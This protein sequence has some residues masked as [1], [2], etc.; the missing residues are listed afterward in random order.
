MTQFCI[1]ITGQRPTV[2]HHACNTF[3]VSKCWA[4]I[5]WTLKNDTDFSF[6]LS[7]SFLIATGV[8]R[9][10]YY[11]NWIPYIKHKKQWNSHEY[12][13]AVW[14]FGEEICPSDP[15]RIV[16]CRSLNI[17]E[18]W[19]QKHHPMSWFFLIINHWQLPG[20]DPNGHGIFQKE[21]F[22][23]AFTCRAFYLTKAFSSPCHIT[24]N[25]HTPATFGLSEAKS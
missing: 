1:F 15:S 12:T 19:P 6:P 21:T 22:S 23:L 7:K 13:K 5:V 14:T 4:F 24:Q 3:V 25:K 11:A 16:D 10:I 17:M 9:S 20:Q 8:Q 2:P 18:W